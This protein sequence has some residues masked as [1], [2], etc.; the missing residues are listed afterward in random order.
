[1]PDDWIAEATVRQPRASPG[2]TMATTSFITGARRTQ[3]LVAPATVGDH[4]L[5]HLKGPGVFVSAQVSRQN[6]PAG[7][8]FLNLD[9]DGVNVVATSFEALKNLALVQ[10]NPFGAMESENGTISTITIGYCLPLKFEKELILKVTV[11]EM[12]VAQILANVIHGT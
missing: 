9:L 5:V 8:T 3:G 1:M 4:V 12:G 6:N 10:D 2:A 11:N 7:I